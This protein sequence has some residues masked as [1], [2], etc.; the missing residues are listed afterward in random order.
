MYNDELQTITVPLE[1]LFLDPNNPR[2]WTKRTMRDIPDSRIPDDKIQKDTMERIE[3][4]GVQELYLSFLR[5]GFL[6]LD[7]IVVR[8][9]QGHGDKYVVVEGNRRV[10]ALK[11]LQN[12]ISSG[13]I[14]EEGIDESYL[15]KLNDSISDIDIL[16]YI[17]ANARG[18]AWIFQGIR[19]ISGIKDWE[20]A[21]R[22]QLVTDQ[23]DT[24]GMSFIPCQVISG[25]S[26]PGD[27]S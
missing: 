24:E 23:V 1:H 9:I 11:S 2:F 6:P 25:Y 7:K 16:L 10:A 22:A 15:E 8:P 26:Q 18:I 3:G 5:N 21:Q 4:F 27:A 14:N 20:P 19:H 17:G 12:N 13:T